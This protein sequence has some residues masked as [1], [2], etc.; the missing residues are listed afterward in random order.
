MHYKK[1]KLF[2]CFH[3]SLW[4]VAIL[5]DVYK[6]VIFPSHGKNNFWVFFVNNLIELVAAEN[7][8]LYHAVRS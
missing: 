7:P 6:Q 8:T 1:V 2:I 3:N 5:I 4:H